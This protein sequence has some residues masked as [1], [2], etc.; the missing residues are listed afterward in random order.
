M[1]I[2]PDFECIIE[3]DIGSWCNSYIGPLACRVRAVIVWKANWKPVS[4]YHK[5]AGLNN[6]NLSAHSSESQN[7]KIKVL[8]G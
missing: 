6:R 8:A 5:L 2:L 4:L 3:T 1:V 7:S